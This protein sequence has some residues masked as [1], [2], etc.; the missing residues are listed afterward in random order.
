M[1]TWYYVSDSQERQGP[2]GD[3]ELKGLID[4][5]VVTRDT[6]VWQPGF[7]GWRAAGDALGSVFTVLPPPVPSSAPPSPPR[8]AQAQAQ[9][10]P[11]IVAEVSP[12]APSEMPIT[13]FQV[14]PLARAWPR[15][16]ARVIDMWGLGMLLAF[17]VGA[18]AAAFSP[19]LSL[20]LATMNSTALGLMLLPL[21]G[22]LIALIMTVVG[23][24]PGKA[25][26]GVRV[27]DI[28]DGNRLFFYLGR[29]FKVWLF[30]L[31]AGIP[32]IALF[33][34]IA[35]YKKVAKG[36]P[37]GYDGGNAS[38][39]GNTSGFRLTLG[40]IAA[41]AL[42]MTVIVLETADREA[43]RAAEATQLWTN[44][45]TNRKATISGGW[46]ASELQTNSGRAFY[47][48]SPSLLAEAVLGYENLGSSNY[49]VQD[50]ATALEGAI[51]SDVKLTSEWSPTT[52]NGLPA[53]K[54]S[55][56]AVNQKDT[57]IEVI[58]TLEGGNAWRSL[59]FA[60]GRS[61]SDLPG[62]TT[63][64]NELFRSAIE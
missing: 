17:G 60:V 27:I 22:I 35:Q 50:Y 46:N 14:P 32:I 47:F 48:H 25:L 49:A 8:P 15:F 59:L 61:P 56:T 21:T 39:E 29:E 2:I 40:V 44:P 43:K 33:T 45:V 19:K 23:T 55:A 11:A 51:T 63:L 18:G 1:S 38:V 12:P 30:G 5:G 28:A 26:L 20:Q 58:V 10:E 34:Q 16:W 24:T 13:S 31:G 4:A 42:F 57:N 64:V 37:A 9:E 53:L 6:L 41:I 62:G 7:D 52:V 36:E 3:D 54:A